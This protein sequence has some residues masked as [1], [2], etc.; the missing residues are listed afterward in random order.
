MGIFKSA[1]PVDF[2]QQAYQR[3]QG[4]HHVHTVI[5]QGP[6]ATSLGSMDALSDVVEAVEQAG[7]RLE[8]SEPLDRDQA[9][10]PT[11]LLLFRAAG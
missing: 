8:R 1:T 2:G 11:L 3:R 7:W 6:P 4:G 10:R 5:W 9:G